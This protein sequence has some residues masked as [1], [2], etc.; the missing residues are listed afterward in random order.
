LDKYL[1]IAKKEYDIAMGDFMYQEYKS[2]LDFLSWKTIREGTKLHILES[3]DTFAKRYFSDKRIRQILEYTMVFLGGSPHN[4]PALYAIMS[5]VDF[6]LGVWYP[7]G[8]M[9]EVVKAL[10][11]LA[12][13]HGAHIVCNQQVQ[14]IEVEKNMF[15]SRVIT[16]N[17]TYDCDIVVVNADYHH[18]ETA[19]L[20]RQYISYD[21]R[22]W[23]Q[24]TMGPSAYLLY[25]GFDHS[26]NGLL[27]HNLYLEPTW[28]NHF[29]T[30]FRSH[31]WPR[32]FSYYVSCPSKTDKSVAPAGSENVFVLIPVAPGLEDTEEIREHYCTK[33]FDHLEQLLNRSLRDH[34]VVKR[35]YAHRDFINDYNAYKGTALGM[36]HTLQQTAI[37]RPS[38]KSKKVKNLFYTGNY[39]HPGVGVPMVIISAQI[40]CERILKQYGA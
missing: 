26:I 35:M 40:V 7:Q 10:V 3:I 19:L 25:L 28:E 23:R 33:V 13:A 2:P 8:G 14:H 21:E 31:T 11:N 39:T 37:F 6:N 34:I 15:A 12:Q 22:Y 18:A 4:T 30:I 36:S 17:E 32:E 38:H 27:H 1:E 9:G 16:D 20:D 24:R 5:H 29:N